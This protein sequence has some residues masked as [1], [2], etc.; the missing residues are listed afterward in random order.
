MVSLHIR[1]FDGRKADDELTEDVENSK[2]AERGTMSV[3]KKII[4]NHHLASL[5]SCRAY[6]MKEHVHMTMPGYYKGQRLLA[7]KMYF[8]YNNIIGGM[9]DTY[10]ALAR[11]FSEVYPAILATAPR[12]LGKSYK[13][14]DFPPVSTIIDLFSMKTKFLPVPSVRDWRNDQVDE[15]TLE[16]LKKEAEE[17]TQA[18]FNRAHRDVAEK[19]GNILQRIVLNVTDYD[20]APAG[21]LRDPLFDDIKE[22]AEI[23]PL[24][25]I[26]D[27]P[28]LAKIGESLK[29]D[30]AP[31]DPVEVRKNSDLRDRIKSLST[32]MAET[33]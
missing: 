5:R 30:I 10:K 25:N 27:D 23:I 28:V 24:M 20:K 31:L 15:G 18:M 3:M 7:A 32:K 22:M 11:E 16:R 6:A 1:F 29:K 21:K 13:A 8:R 14:D 26:N 19:I 12:R 33:L 17:D 4:P 9:S 2:D